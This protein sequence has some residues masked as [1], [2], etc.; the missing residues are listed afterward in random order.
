[1]TR[2]EEHQEVAVLTPPHPS[3]SV[4]P[5]AEELLVEAQCAGDTSYV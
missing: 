3:I 1:M 2:K 5:A 4:V